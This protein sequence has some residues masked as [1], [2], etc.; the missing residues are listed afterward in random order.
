[1][2]LIQQYESAKTLYDR[3][4]VVIEMGKALRNKALPE[5]LVSEDSVIEAYKRYIID[6]DDTASA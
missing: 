5:E 2:H 4:A 6:G 3:I 1:M